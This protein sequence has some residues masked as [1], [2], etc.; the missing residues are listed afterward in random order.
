MIF[1]VCFAGLALAVCALLLKNFGWRGAPVFTA[2]CFVF[3]IG[4][5]G[6][7]FS[8]I[9]KLFKIGEGAE[10]SASAILKIIG[11]GYLFGISADVCR[12][13][14]ESS[15]ASAVSLIGRF[16]IIAVALPFINEL[17][18]LALSLIER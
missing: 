11:L 4:F 13:L 15:I 17:L 9:I 5:A 14:G 10:K 1:N 2:I 7:Y 8:E 12:E 16:E 3:I 6:E 18:A